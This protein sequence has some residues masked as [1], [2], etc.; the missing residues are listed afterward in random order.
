M[1][2]FEEL[3][4]WTDCKVAVLENGRAAVLNPADDSESAW[5]LFQEIVE[6]IQEELG[7]DPEFDVRP[8][9]NMRDLPGRRG[10]PVYNQVTVTKLA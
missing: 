1:A 9:P 3:C 7:G 8:H 10:R 6:E 5:I 2:F 4:R